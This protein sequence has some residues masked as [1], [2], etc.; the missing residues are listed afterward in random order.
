MYACVSGC[1]TTPPERKAGTPGTRKSA[2]RG[3]MT[4]LCIRIFVRNV[5]GECQCLQALGAGERES[6]RESWFWLDEVPRRLKV[7]LIHFCTVFG[8]PV[9]I[10]RYPTE[11]P[12]IAQCPTT[13]TTTAV[14]AVLILFNRFQGKHWLGAI[15]SSLDFAIES[16]ESWKSS[17]TQ[18]N[19][20]SVPLLTRDRNG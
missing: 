3:R 12:G 14:N 20:D 9:D 6:W 16:E 4:I 8:S 15:S 11:G 18:T 1:R 19:L 10:V 2:R 13:T 5:N 17:S 7:G